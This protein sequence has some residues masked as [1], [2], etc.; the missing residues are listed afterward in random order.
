[1]QI[2]GGPK[3]AHASLSIRRVIDGP[4]AIVIVISRFLKRY[5][6]AKRTRATAYSRALH[7]IRG[8]VQ[9]IV[10]GRLR[11]G[12]RNRNLRIS[13][14]GCPEVDVRRFCVQFLS[15]NG[16]GALYDNNLVSLYQLSSIYI[17]L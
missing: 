9:S 11:S 8:V 17:G 16:I 4:C 6:K 7:Q 12:Y 3:L 1:L 2:P 10:R 13:Q 5:L 15:Y 14:S